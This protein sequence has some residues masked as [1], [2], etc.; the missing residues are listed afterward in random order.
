ML[1]HRHEAQTNPSNQT[2]TLAFWMWNGLGLRMSQ[3]NTPARQASVIAHPVRPQMHLC[4]GGPT[5][6]SGSKTTRLPF[7]SPATVFY[8]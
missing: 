2:L 8:I 6:A 7:R 4:P 3:E 1:P 5:T